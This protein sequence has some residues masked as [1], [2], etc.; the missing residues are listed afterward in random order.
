MRAAKA[1]VVLMAVTTLAGSG[2]SSMPDVMSDWDRQADFSEYRTFAWLEPDS[3]EDEAY[4]LPDHLDRRLRR[5]VTD[6]LADKGF[7]PAPIP[8]AADLLLTY[9][10]SI[11]KELRVDLVGYSYYGGYRYGYWPGSTFATARMREYSAGTLVVDIIDRETGQAVWTGVVTG[12]AQSENPSGDRIQTV[13][14]AMLDEF[15]PP[16]GR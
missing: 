11:Q 15:P 9:Y 14:E 8:P 1:T 16:T 4:R 6:V 13:M 3:S 10:I 12:T 5:V 2:C 7:E